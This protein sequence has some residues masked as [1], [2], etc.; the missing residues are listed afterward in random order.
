[1]ATI[2]LNLSSDSIVGSGGATLTFQNLAAA[3][4]NQFEPRFSGAGFNMAS[5]IVIAAGLNA[6]TRTTRLSSA[7]A[8]GTQTFSGVIS[9]AGAYRRMAGGTT[10]LA[11]ANTY[12][13]GTEVEGGTLTASGAAATFGAG[14]VTVTGGNLEIASGVTDAIADSATLS[15]M[16]GGTPGMADVAYANLGTGVNERVLALLLNGLVQANGTYGSTASAAMFQMNEYFAGMGLLTVG[17]ASLPGDYN[18]D[19]KVNAADYVTW[20]NNPGGFPVDAYDTW[21]ANFGN[22]PGSGSSLGEGA[23][24]PEPAA[25]VLT[26]LAAGCAL[27]GMVRMRVGHARL[28]GKWPAFESLSRMPTGA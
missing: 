20:R 14:N 22:P 2:D 21:R 5:P 25:L 1:V 11:A 19:G 13:G 16:G 17:P 10:V 23:A 12:S 15:L 6:A 9:G 26:V 8:T 7:N 28:A 24:V 18:G 4:T 27:V 3:G